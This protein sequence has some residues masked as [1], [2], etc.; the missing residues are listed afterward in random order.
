M[1]DLAPKNTRML[2]EKWSRKME[3][4]AK[5]GVEDVHLK[6][7]TVFD[8]QPVCAEYLKNG[9]KFGKTFFCKVVDHDETLTLV[10]RI[11]KFVFFVK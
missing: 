4:V 5:V 8:L 1:A 6:N 3:M 2:M 10:D 11:S 9:A 7:T